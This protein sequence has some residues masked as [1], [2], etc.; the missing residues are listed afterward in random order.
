MCD[1]VQF[2]FSVYVRKPLVNGNLTFRK[3]IDMKRNACPYYL[4]TLTPNRVEAKI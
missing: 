3:I 1:F 2:N 4:I